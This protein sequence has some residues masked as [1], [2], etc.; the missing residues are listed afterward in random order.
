MFFPF[1]GYIHVWVIEYD[2]RFTYFIFFY[3]EA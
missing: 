2:S 3:Y 1:D